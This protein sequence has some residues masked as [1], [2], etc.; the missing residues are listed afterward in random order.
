[1]FVEDV[2]FTVF[3]KENVLAFDLIDSG[4]GRGDWYG[5]WPGVVRPL[6][7]WT[8]EYLGEKVKV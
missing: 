5:K 4:V 8:T 6:L 2:R 7:N 1:M 3:V